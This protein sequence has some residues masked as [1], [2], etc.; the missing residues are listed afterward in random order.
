MSAVVW[1][2]AVCALHNGGVFVRRGDDEAFDGL[3]APG[4]HGPHMGFNG[5]Q[6]LLV[7]VRQEFPRYFDGVKRMLKAAF[8]VIAELILAPY[9]A[10]VMAEGG[11]NHC[12]RAEFHVQLIEDRADHKTDHGHIDGMLC[13]GGREMMFLKKGTLE[14]TGFHN[15]DS[16]VQQR[17]PESVIR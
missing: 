6:R 1:G 4:P 15:V 11:L 17:I 2:S 9:D 8:E 12:F 14:L 10:Q 3:R 5:F 16:V 13:N 7:A